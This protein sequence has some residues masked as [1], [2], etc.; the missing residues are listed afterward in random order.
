MLNPIYPLMLEHI[1]SILQ[2]FF[3]EFCSTKHL[4]RV[5]REYLVFVPL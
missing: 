4:R 3:K 5:E 1:F 2:P